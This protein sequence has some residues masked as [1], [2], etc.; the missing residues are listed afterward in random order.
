MD[1]SPSSKP[2]EDS[3]KA[4]SQAPSQ[5]GTA[6]PPWPRR[7][8][9]REGHGLWPPFHGCHL[10]SALPEESTE[11]P[12]R[13]TPPSSCSVSVGGLGLQPETPQAS[14]RQCSVLIRLASIR[15]S[16]QPLSDW[17]HRTLRR[18]EI[19]SHHNSHHTTDKP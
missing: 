2:T 12:Q 13:Q 1:A 19:T 5:C 18:E 9:R 15:A 14:E 16:F 6:V 11:H 3:S 4:S 10:H 7:N 17:S 8:R